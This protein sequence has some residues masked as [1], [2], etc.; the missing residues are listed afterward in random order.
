MLEQSLSLKSYPLKSIVHTLVFRLL[1]PHVPRHIDRHLRSFELDITPTPHPFEHALTNSQRLIEDIRAVRVGQANPSVNRGLLVSLFLLRVQKLSHF[2]QCSL[3]PELLAFGVFASDR[4]CVVEVFINLKHLLDLFVGGRR[5]QELDRRLPLL[6]IF[7]RGRDIHLLQLLQL[8]LLPGNLF[9]Q[10]LV[11][12][13]QVS[14]G[15][16]KAK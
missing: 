9:F 16:L 3:Y 12:V 7:A 13:P 5:R 11:L 2:I 15:F 14:C 1:P 6:K 8:C 10:L 4:D